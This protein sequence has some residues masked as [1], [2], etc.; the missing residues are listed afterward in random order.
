MVHH[1]HRAE[2]R[3]RGPRGRH[4]GRSASVES[5]AAS[6]GRFARRAAPRNRALPARA[7]GRAIFHVRSP[8]CSF[9]ASCRFLVTALGQQVP[10]APP[11]APA[12][13]RAGASAA[14][15]ARRHPARRVRPVSRQQRPALLPPRRPR[16][17]GEEVHRRQEHHPLQDAQGRHA[18]PARPATR[19]STSTR[20]CWATTPLKYER[21]LG[22]VFVDF[23]ETL[24]AGRDVRHRLLLLRHARASR[25]AS[26]ASPSARIR[27]GVHWIYTACEGRG[28]EHLVAEQGPV[29]R[30]SRVDGDQRRHPQRPG[31][32]SPT[33][34]SSARPT[35]ATATRAGT[36]RCSTRS[37]TTASR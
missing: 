9:L 8:A 37:T 2:R 3:R 25:A 5:A 27:P 12:P 35:S 36:G 21:E 13:A 23:P 11:P 6:G 17:S 1:D 26:A 33:A 32:T 34:S 10:P 7:Q 14:A 28:R 30:R 29:A 24:K 20:S 22:A 15:D 16:R 31:R 4:A 19:T 18:H